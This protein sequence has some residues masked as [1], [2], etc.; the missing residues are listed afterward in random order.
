MSFF[1]AAAAAA[2]RTTLTLNMHDMASNIEGTNRLQPLCM[3]PNLHAPLAA[4]TATG[5]L[6]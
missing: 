4:Q 2:E 5:P 3:F 6:P 1:A